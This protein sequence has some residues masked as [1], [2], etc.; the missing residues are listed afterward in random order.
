M[1][2]VVVKPELFIKDFVEIAQSFS[3]EKVLN[4]FTVAEKYGDIY[5]KRFLLNR[6]YTHQNLLDD[7]FLAFEFFIDHSFRRGRSD[8]LSDKYI[9]LV[10]KEL[11]VLEEEFADF[12]AVLDRL[13]KNL[14]EKIPEKDIQHLQSLI[15]FLK[16]CPGHNLYVYVYNEIYNGNTERLFK[17]L[18]SINYV[19]DK[20]ASFIIR[21][22]I[23]IGEL[24]KHIDRVDYIFPIDTHVS[25]FFKSLGINMDEKGLPC[26]I[27]EDLLKR[28]S[29]SVAKIA[30]GMWYIHFYSFDILRR[31]MVEGEDI[32]GNF[33]LSL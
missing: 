31:T 5:K 27:E 28:D 17:N 10:L 19:G 30:A 23:L 16:K 8:R 1:A 6:G 33:K 11:Y 12:L 22:T 26:F 7:K 24:R 15:K 13:V 20:L 25:S 3:A 4:V 32:T 21:D 2:K 9:Q 18:K 29:L 14:Q